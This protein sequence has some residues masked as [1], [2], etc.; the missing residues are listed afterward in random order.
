[1]TR[2]TLNAPA[3]Q[4]NIVM[5]VQSS[6]KGSLGIMSVTITKVYSISREAA[7]VLTPRVRNS[8]CKS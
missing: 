2:Y 6:D 8:K 3:R 7:V 1:M 5:P 4:R